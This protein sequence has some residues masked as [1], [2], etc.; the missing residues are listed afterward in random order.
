MNI[1]FYSDGKSIL[2]NHVVVFLICFV[3][4][5]WPGLP[6]GLAPPNT[7]GGTCERI[8]FFSTGRTLAN[9]EHTTAICSCCTYPERQPDLNKIVLGGSPQ[10]RERTMLGGKT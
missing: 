9:L 5:T 2:W 10:E 3:C 4:Y 8:C 7:V 6:L 1:F